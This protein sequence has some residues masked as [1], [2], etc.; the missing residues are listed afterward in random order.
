MFCTSPV[1]N[2]KRYVEIIS[3][4]AEAELR[5]RQFSSI[6]ARLVDMDAINETSDLSYS[7]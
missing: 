5:C 6:V 4:S 7:T 1:L 3:I 2:S